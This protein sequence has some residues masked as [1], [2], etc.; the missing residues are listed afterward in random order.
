MIQCRMYSQNDDG[1]DETDT[2]TGYKTS[3]NH[4]IEASRSS[5]KDTTDNEDQATN[6]D[7]KTTTNEVGNISRND[8]TEEGTGGKNRSNQG[9]LP[10]RN[11]ECSCVVLQ[12]LALEA[13]VLRVGQ[14]GVLSD[15]VGHGKDTTHP[16][17]VISEEDTTKG[18]EGDNEVC[19]HSDGGLDAIDIGRAGDGNNSSTRH[20]CRWMLVGLGRG[21]EEED[22]K[23]RSRP[24]SRELEL[25][26]LERPSTS[27]QES[28]GHVPFNMQA[29][30][31]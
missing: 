16:S 5:L 18:G 13:S 23:A 21:K 25:R 10:L 24:K 30:G 14:A 17:C 26:E 4:D 20:D 27:K 29:P 22:G 3:T 6:D 11:D 12:R 2:E 9:L 31:P 7:S 19:P 28:A 15:E 8:G 1:R